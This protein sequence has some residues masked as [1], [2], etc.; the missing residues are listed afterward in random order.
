MTT[1]I[2]P[3]RDRKHSFHVKGSETFLNTSWNCCLVSSSDPELSITMSASDFFQSRASCALI[4]F[5]ACSSEH[6]SLD[7]S[8]SIWVS[9]LTQTTMTGFV[10]LSIFVSNNSGMSRTITLHPLIHSFAI[11]QNMP[12]EICGAR[13]LKLNNKLYMKWRQSWHNIFTKRY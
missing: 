4:L 13:R 9:G 2:R 11:S 3:S 1:E 12:D 10:H 8:L 7:M 5:W 6:P